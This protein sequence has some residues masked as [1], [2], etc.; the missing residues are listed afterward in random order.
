MTRGERKLWVDTVHAA[1]SGGMHSNNAA[2]TA[3]M[4]VRRMATVSIWTRLRRKFG[5][6]ARKAL[7]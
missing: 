5:I 1:L 2:Q 4:V 7:S 6:P 3:D